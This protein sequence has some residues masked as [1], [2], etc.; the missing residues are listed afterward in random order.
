M[1]KGFTLIELLVVIAIISLLS[2]I[3][4]AS[5]SSA[6]NK[7]GN[8][9]I[10]EDLNNI[11]SQAEIIYSSNSSYSSVCLNTNVQNMVTAAGATCNPSVSAWA[12]QAT[13]KTPESGNAYWCIDNTG[14]GRGD[15][16]ALGG[17]TVCP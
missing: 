16:V 8:A 6:R 7:G 17:G 2:S 4:L 13:L 11:R 9:A 15:N 14:N 5:L 12:A 3:I 10:K 1:K